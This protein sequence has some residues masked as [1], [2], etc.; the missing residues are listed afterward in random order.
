MREKEMTEK[1]KLKLKD[2]FIE[3]KTIINYDIQ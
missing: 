2:E 1:L 3:R